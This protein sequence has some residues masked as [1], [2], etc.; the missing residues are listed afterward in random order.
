MTGGG[1]AISFPLRTKLGHYR[2]LVGSLIL[3]RRRAIP[4]IRFAALTMTS[5]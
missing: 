3:I 1:L 4:I 5:V 2:T